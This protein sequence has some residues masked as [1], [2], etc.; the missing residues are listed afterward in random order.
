MSNP[1]AFRSSK[2]VLGFIGGFLLLVGI[3]MAVIGF[4]DSAVFLGVVGLIIAV[5]GVVAAVLALRRKAT[6]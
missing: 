2:T 3:A 6:R 4:T 1:N 5:C